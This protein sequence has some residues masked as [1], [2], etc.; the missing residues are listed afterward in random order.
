[1]LIETQADPSL[2]LDIPDL[3]ANLR[4]RV[5]AFAKSLGASTVIKGAFVRN[6]A[7]VFVSQALIELLTVLGSVDFLDNLASRLARRMALA[8]SFCVSGV[9]DGAIMRIFCKTQ[10]FGT[11]SPASTNKS[12]RT[13]VDYNFNDKYQYYMTVTTSNSD[14]S[15]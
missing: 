15:E 4:A 10:V 9:S 2:Y 14:S 5:I 11:K 12:Q 3:L 8:K 6:R 7:S 1:M 13:N